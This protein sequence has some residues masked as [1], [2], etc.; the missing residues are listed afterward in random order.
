MSG[1]IVQGLAIGASVVTPLLVVG[2]LAWNN[3]SKQGA[4]TEALVEVQNGRLRVVEA[5]KMPRGECTL[6]HQQTTMVVEQLKEGAAELKN[7]LRN[8]AAANKE[9]IAATNMMRAE[10]GLP[11]LQ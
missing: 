9:M 2:L 10:K 7:E 6:L 5:S 8:Y 1:V 11:P 4:R 3:L